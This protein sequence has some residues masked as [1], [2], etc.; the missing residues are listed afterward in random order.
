M[1]VPT[2][3]PTTSGASIFLLQRSRR[4]SRS[5]KISVG[6]EKQNPTAS[7]R[8]HTGTRNSAK[9]SKKSRA[10]RALPS[11]PGI[12]YFWKSSTRGFPALSN[13]TT[14]TR[15]LVPPASSTTTGVSIGT[16]REESM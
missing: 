6:Y 9:V 10:E 14:A 3:S 11:V 7:E 5:G 16:S 13:H 12:R 8:W 1:R 4:P 15:R 2:R